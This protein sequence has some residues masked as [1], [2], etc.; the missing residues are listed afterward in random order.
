MDHI[1]LLVVKDTFAVL[2]P[3]HPFS[4]VVFLRSKY[5]STF[6]MLAT[7]LILAF[8][9]RSITPGELTIAMH[10]TF[11]PVAIVS[12]VIREDSSALT[13]WSERFLVDKSIESPAVS[14]DYL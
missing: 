4:S 14:V 2:F 10:F 7:V 8:V 3:V 6:P 12:A 1:T 11:L 9:R 5:E 13:L